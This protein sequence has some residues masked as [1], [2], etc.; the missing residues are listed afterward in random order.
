MRYEVM[1]NRSDQRLEILYCLSA[2]R[3]LE[4]NCCLSKVLGSHGV[5]LA[6]FSNSRALYDSFHTWACSTATLLIAFPVSC[7]LWSSWQSK[8]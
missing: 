6:R 1:T 8:R 3:L 2:E 5:G 4:P 7:T